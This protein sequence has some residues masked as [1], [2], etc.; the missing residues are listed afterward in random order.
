MKLKILQLILSISCTLLCPA[1]FAQVKLPR[2]ISD[3]MV[4]QRD[5]PLKIWGWAAPGEKVVVNFNHKTYH[6]TT[7][8]DGKWTV[9][10]QPVKS[11]GPFQM[12]IDARNHLVINDILVGDVW[13][14]SGQSN[15]VLPM[16]RVKEKYPDEIANANYPQIRNFFIPTIAD[17]TGLHQDL[18]PGKWMVA[19]P[20]NVM[21]FGAASWFF[22]KTL[23]QKYR[24][25][26][27]IINSSVGGTP[28]EAWISEDGLKEF[29]GYLQAAAKYKDTAL[30]N[31]INRTA[32]TAAAAFNQ[33]NK[34]NDKG[35]S[36]EKPWYDT[37]YTAVSWH[38]LMIPGYW[39]DQG[40]HGLNGVVWYRKEID[41]PRE[42]AGTA[43]KLYMGR[44]VDA[45][46]LY[47]NGVM[48]G[49]TTYQYPPRRYTVAPGLLKPGKNI[50]VVRVIN[51][52]GKGGFVPDKPYYL[53]AGG[54][55]MDLRGDWQFKVG[56][57]F[58]PV[59]L[60]QSVSVQ[61]QPTS[62]FN[63]MIAPL[64]NY[65]VKGF[66]WYQGESSTA[67]PEE[68]GHLL[69]ALIADWRKLWQQGDVPFVYAQLPNFM[70]AQYIPAESQWAVVREGQLKALSVPHTGMAV[71]IDAGEWNDVHPLDKKDVGER[72]ALAAEKVAYHDDK[73]V[74]SGPVYQSAVIDNNH[75]ILSFSNTGSGLVAKGDE[76]LS[77]FAI[78]GADK[79]FV[80]AK[81][82]MQ[83]DKVVV[84]NDKIAHPLYVRYAWADNPDGANLYNKE[85]LPAS[86]FRTDGQ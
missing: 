81:A 54:H 38:T 34:Q 23:Y 26:V 17:L 80:W 49:A 45:D 9:L 16:E 64:I 77:Y 75:I 57:V 59:R 72:L 5:I 1:A 12:R 40:I 8:N 22:A 4:L 14:C 39:A 70:E 67:R 35:L 60:P 86:P 68:Y 33:P 27:G 84:W 15:M 18:P 79:R 20:D 58:E 43:A 29:P 11:G 30:V 63:A 73:V 36:G 82:V 55:R 50:I 10:M 19:S 24:I 61:N 46:Q 53:L 71:T 13:L 47:V 83:G 62:L 51:Y 41:I 66:L 37:T 48:V 56:Q 85:G 65:K 25:P 7:G 6:A 2:L 74:Y 31:R 3:G 78:A 52:S 44:I 32:F 28:I 21:S 42:M 69:P 76:G